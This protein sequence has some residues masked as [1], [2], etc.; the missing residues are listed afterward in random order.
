MRKGLSQERLALVGPLKR[1]SHGAVVVANE[2]EDFG[3]ELV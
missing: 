2:G 1:F 3:F